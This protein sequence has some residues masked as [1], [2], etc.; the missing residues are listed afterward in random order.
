[1]EK[2]IWLLHNARM[3]ARGSLFSWDF[4][5]IREKGTTAS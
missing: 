3:V 5:E 1:M 2:V 4:M